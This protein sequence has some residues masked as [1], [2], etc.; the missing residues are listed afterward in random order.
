M[1]DIAHSPN[2]AKPNTKRTIL[3]TVVESHFEWLCIER[4]R[5]LFISLNGN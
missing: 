2:P 3:R 1:I 5:K 4:K